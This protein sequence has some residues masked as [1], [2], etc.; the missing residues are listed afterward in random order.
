MVPAA[1]AQV[2]QSCF[3]AWH[4]DPCDKDHSARAFISERV[5]AYSVAPGERGKGI[6]YGREEGKVLLGSCASY[7]GRRTGESIKGR[8][9]RMGR[10]E[11]APWAW[12]MTQTTSRTV[13]SRPHTAVDVPWQ[14]DVLPRSNWGLWVLLWV[15]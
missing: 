15:G 4:S 3:S 1:A 2:L 8:M 6:W 7:L 14:L 9:F 13:L 10:F 12:G 11:S 5:V